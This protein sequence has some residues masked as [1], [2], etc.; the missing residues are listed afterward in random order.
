MATPVQIPQLPRR[1]RQHLP[2]SLTKLSVLVAPA[3]N[4]GTE[5]DRRRVLFAKRT[6]FFDRPQVIARVSFYSRSEEKAFF[7]KRTL[8]AV[9][10][11]WAKDRRNYVAEGEETAFFAKRE[12]MEWPKAA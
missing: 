5:R 2:R 9:W 10:V 7:A 6:Q 4:T 1:Q 3:T 8:V 12:K 11:F